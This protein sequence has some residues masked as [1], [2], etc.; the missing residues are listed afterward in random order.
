MCGPITLCEESGNAGVERETQTV[1]MRH[2]TAKV[3]HGRGPRDLSRVR[4][5]LLCNRDCIS[6]FV[7]SKTQLCLGNV[8]RREALRDAVS[9]KVDLDLICGDVELVLLSRRKLIPRLTVAV[10]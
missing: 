7:L 10:R 3:A 8:R 9:E 1:S 2:I 6:T 5:A 4:G